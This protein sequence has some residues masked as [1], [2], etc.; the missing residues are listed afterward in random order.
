MAGH[1]V[2]ILGLGFIGASLGLALKQHAGTT[3]IGFDPDA[4]ALRRARSRKAIDQQ[5]ASSGEAIR[6][7]DTVVL[8]A[9]VREIIHLLREVGPGLAEGTLVTDTGST[10]AAIVAQAEQTLPAGVAFVG[11]HPLAGRLRSQVAEADPALFVGAT[12]CL[13]PTP[14]SPEWGID[15]ATQMVEAVGAVPHFLDADEHD[16]LLAAVSHL[17]YFASAA[18]VSAVGRQQ[19]WNEMGALAAGGFRAASSLVDGSPRMWTDIA[20]T[21]AGPLGRQIGSLIEV[22][23]QLQLDLAAGDTVKLNATLERA[24]AIH[25]DWVQT[26]EASSSQ[27]ADRRPPTRPK[28]RFPFL[29]G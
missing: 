2:A 4:E 14:D 19:G 11:G 18:L 17:P 10:K 6:G 24:Y 15:R 3:V 22:L 7:A 13:C 5:A 26:Q 8:A 29:R 25:R 28:R 20:V 1:Q 12:Y 27:V 21:N 23:K 9:P 16:A